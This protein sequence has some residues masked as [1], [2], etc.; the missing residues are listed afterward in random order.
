MSFVPLIQKTLTMISN[1][2]LSDPS[3][4][5]S[6]STLIT[7]SN[8]IR[9]ESITISSNSE[10]YSWICI[11][12]VIHAVIHVL[13]PELKAKS[14]T[15]QT[16]SL[17]AKEF[18]KHPH[19]LVQLEY[20]Q[21]LQSLILFAPHTVLLVEDIIPYLRSQFSSNYSILRLAAVVCLRQLV[22]ISNSLT[23]KTNTSVSSISSSSNQ[24]TSSNQQTS[25]SNQTTSSN[26][27]SNNNF[28]SQ[29]EEHLFSMVSK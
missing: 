20:I 26:Q 5:S 16:C 14:T 29:L 22:P 13:G 11:G 19:P 25:S 15:M 28:S 9:N 24:T 18:K 6:N 17:I 8:H 21:F 2:L 23:S 1:M 7:V 4:S 27:S 10:E 12:K 3:S